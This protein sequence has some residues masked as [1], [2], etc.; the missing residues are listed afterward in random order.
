MLDKPKLQDIQPEDL[1]R[2]VANRVPESR[3]L[4]Y[5]QSLPG[6][7]DSDRKEFLAD[8]S[9][10]ANAVGGD[11]IYGVVETRENNRATGVPQSVD[12]LD[13][14]NKDADLQR[15]EN[16][17]RDGIAPRLPGLQFRWIDGFPAGP[18]LV[19]RVPR[20]WAGPHMVT[21]QQ[22]SRFYSRTAAGKYPLDVFELRQSFLASGSLPERAREFRTE[23]LG[24]L[25]AGELPV[26][27][28]SNHLICMHF[29]PHSAIAGAGD[30]DVLLA[31]N[32][33]ENLRPLYSG[34]Y[35][36]RFNLDGVLTYSPTASGSNMAFLQVYRNGI[37]E[38]VS[39]ALLSPRP[40][41]GGSGLPS[42]AFAD[43]LFGFVTRA[44]N[45]A[46]TLGIEPPVS[47]FVS[48]LGTRDLLLGI[49]SRLTFY[50]DH[51]ARPFDRDNLLF[52]DVLLTDWS[53]D[54]PVT[55]KPLLDELWQAAGLARCFDYNDAGNWN[56]DRTL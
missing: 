52:R 42:L 17:L 48:L 14:A 43:H 18:V 47:V 44:K 4:E 9:S 39:S 24:R 50:N 51:H 22:H 16:I 31:A 2:L 28:T 53:G 23:R 54:L 7:T 35:G 15:L 40:D 46:R 5:K 38:T 36:W 37:I 21:Y 34:S 56:P 32:Q 25:L 12:G 11:L 30:I 6:G 41:R 49:D 8:V 45:L 20:S 55:F 13:V 29:I 1:E 27:L 33:G 3:S 10:F 19:I 26:Q